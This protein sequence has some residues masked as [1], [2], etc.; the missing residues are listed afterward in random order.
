[1]RANEWSSVDAVVARHDL[2]GLLGQPDADLFTLSSILSAACIYL[3]DPML[4]DY[5]IEGN[6]MMRARPAGLSSAKEVVSF[7]GQRQWRLVGTA[8]VALHRPEQSQTG[9]DAASKAELAIYKD[10]HRF[11]SISY[12]FW[13]EQAVVEGLNSA[14]FYRI[15]QT[16]QIKQ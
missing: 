14:K 6:Q 5:D 4:E 12:D 16:K 13:A 7:V 1:L 9:Q 15:Q 2:P 11:L 10:E 3:R 8:N